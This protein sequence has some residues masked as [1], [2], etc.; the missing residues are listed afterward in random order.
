MLLARL[1]AETVLSETFAFRCSRRDLRYS[2]ALFLKLFITGTRKFDRGLSDLLH[3]ELHW[4]EIYQRVQYKL[5]VTICRCLQNRAPQYLVDFCV[6]TSDVSSRQRLRSANRRQ[7][8]VPRHRR[9]KFGRRSRFLELVSTLP[10][11]PNAE[12]RHLQIDIKNSPVRGATG[13]VAD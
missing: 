13:H 1:P 7:L 6:R 5:G 12:H 8:V 10:S 4:L 3:S 11:G 2:K 9:S